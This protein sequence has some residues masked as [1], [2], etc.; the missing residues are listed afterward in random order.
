M[1]AR[2]AAALDGILHPR[3]PSVKLFLAVVLAALSFGAV[4]LAQ[5]P[6]GNMQKRFEAIFS[7]SVAPNSPGLA[8]LVK[9]EG[10]VL[11]ER[12][13]GIRDL[14]SRAKIDSNTNFRLASVTKQFTAMAVMLLVHDRKLTYDT[15]LSEIFP[16]FPAYGA[17]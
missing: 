14:R 8:V 9:K 3:R 11:F 6:S 17:R 4:A 7:E 5:K 16:E 10:K 1:P 12:G 15:K 2:L 13:Y